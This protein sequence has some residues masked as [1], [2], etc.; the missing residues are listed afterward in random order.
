MNIT[1][2]RNCLLVL[3]QH[4]CV[5]GFKIF[6]EAV[7][8]NP[9]KV[10]T[11][12]LGLTDNILHRMRFPK[13]LSIVRDELGEEA[14]ALLEGLLEHGRLTLEQVVQRA[15]A[16]AGKAE[17][18]VELPLKQ[19]FAAL[20]R[21]HYIERCPASE[22]TVA[23]KAIEPPKKVPRGPN[24]KGRAA[25]VAAIKNLE[26]DYDRIVSVAAALDTER[27]RMPSSLE[28]VGETGGGDVSMTD[29]VVPGQKRKR[30]ALAM[31]AKTMAI[32]DEKEVLWRANYEELIRKLRHQACVAQVK[33]RIDAAAGSVL[34]A[35]LEMTRS[36]ETTSK[37]QVSAPLSMTVIMQAVTMTPEGR[38]MTMERIRGAL[39]QMAQETVGFI[40][41]TGE[42]GSSYIISGGHRVTEIWTGKLSNIQ[43][44][45]DEGADGTK[46]GQL[47]VVL[48]TIAGM[49]M[50]QLKDAREL[51]YRL[52]KEQ[53]VVVQEV[54][55]T[56][57]HSAQKSIYLWN[58]NWD[59]VKL[60]VL[61]DMYHAAGNLQQRLSHELEQEQEVLELLKQIQAAKAAGA[62]THVTL[63]QRQHEQVKRIRRVASILEASLLK[64]DNAIL[65]FYDF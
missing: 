42:G 47:N 13:F 2:L 23:P 61:D 3:V 63:T 5:Q 16:R 48:M 46:T 9:P 30:D 34:A 36:S 15:A 58:I 50:V 65:L 54:A 52:L 60:L 10:L 17:S 59:V 25:K 28:E 20:V 7:G 35:M 6:Q 1:Q 8:P 32:V 22:P 27:F 38:T 33:T 55:K 4:N 37:P 21:S 39:H 12:Y 19:T 45:D 51:L 62:E 64:L 14:E 26:S 56:A 24:S 31:D 29:P 49:A 44:L 53:Y 40:T 41:R 11:S 57:E 43:A 18:E